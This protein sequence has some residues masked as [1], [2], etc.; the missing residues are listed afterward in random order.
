M[1]KNSKVPT[2]P[3]AKGG[4]NTSPPPSSKSGRL[5][6]FTHF[7]THWDV[8][9]LFPPDIT[10][11]WGIKQVWVYAVFGREICPTTK[12]QHWQCFI[13][14]NDKKTPLTVANVLE[15]HLG[16]RP[17]VILCRGTI[18]ENYDY[19]S[20]E[21]DFYEWGKKPD[22]KKSNKESNKEPEIIIEPD[23]IT[24]L[25]PFQQQILD[26]YNG[27]INKGKVNWIYDPT[28]QLG[29]TE[30]LRYMYI[31]H[32]VP[33]SYGGKCADIINLVFNNKKQF[34]ETEKP[35]MIYNFGRET[36]PNEI[37]YKSMEQVSDGAISNTKFEAGCFV[38]PKKPHIFVFA[39][40][41]PLMEK[42]TKSRWIIYTIDEN[43]NLINYEEPKNELDHGI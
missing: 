14:L 36:K 12:N 20:K 24:E 38:M 18:D 23:V 8:P 16:K 4:G 33:F 42:L 10:T 25:R 17:H 7:S 6:C 37:S 2:V 3:T 9:N 19:C 32:K 41:L 21:K 15:K 39:N 28:G 30:M 11:I 1:P 31:H 13:Y 29:K 5:F 27:P 43:M 34:C 40:C 26:I 22:G 35:T